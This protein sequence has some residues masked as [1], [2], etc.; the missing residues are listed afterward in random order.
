MDNISIAPTERSPHVEFDF[1]QGLF[2]LEGESYP[3]DSAAFFAPILQCLRA[4]LESG[5]S[6]PVVFDLTMSYFNSSS[7]KALMNMFQ[8]LEDAAAMG[9]DVVVNWHYHPDDDTM[10]EFGEDFGLDFEN[11]AFRMCPTPES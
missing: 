10:E 7:A 2:L 8:M 6:R 3:E 5:D 9:R 11:A 4:F 1:A